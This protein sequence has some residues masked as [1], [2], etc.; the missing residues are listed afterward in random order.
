MGID[1]LFGRIWRLRWF[2][3]ASSMISGMAAIGATYLLP[4]RYAGIAE[5][6]MDSQ[7]NSEQRSYS[8]SNKQV[9]TYVR[10]Q[11]ELVKD[12]RVTGRVV[13]KLNWT[14]SNELAQ[15]YNTYGRRTGLDF[16][17]WLASRISANTSLQF[18]E[19]SSGFAIIYAGFDPQEAKSMAGLLRDA[20][21]EYLLDRRRADARGQVDWVGKRKAYLEEQIRTLEKRSAEFSKKTGVVLTQDGLALAEIRLRNAASAVEIE[22]PT[23]L[24]GPIVS[25][26]RKN[27]TA[28]EGQLAA[29]SQTLGPNHPQIK[30]LEEKRDALQQSVAA[31]ER[32]RVVPT[33]PP[34][35]PSLEKI[36]SEFLAKANDIATAKRYFTELQA[37]QQQYQALQQSSSNAQLDSNTIQSGAQADDEPTATGNVYYPDYRFSIPMAFA[38]GAVLAILAG[39]LYSLLNMRVRTVKDLRIMNIPTFD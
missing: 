3:L 32:A 27:L 38:L 33:P 26:E 13:D 20:Y 29:L 23:T 35:G 17:T 4:H 12:Y 22:Q 36:R 10:S 39:L 24:P 37:L 18:E 11:A 5:V 8:I 16:R 15:Q 9:D 21:I 31:A 28:V 30:D 6:S 19:G 7:I 2:I 34:T 1:Q 25:L 14:S